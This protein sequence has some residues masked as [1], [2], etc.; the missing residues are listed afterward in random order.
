MKKTFTAAEVAT[1]NTEADC[2]VIVAG[3]VF[4]VT[5]YLPKHPGG[6]QLVSRSAGQDVTKV[7]KEETQ[8]TKEKT[9]I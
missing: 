2:W 9:E 4:D 8:E 3:R 6:K 5:A 1:H 7:Q